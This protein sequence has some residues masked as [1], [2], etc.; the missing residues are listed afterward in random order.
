MKTGMKL[1]TKYYKRR[2]WKISY[3]ATPLSHNR[4]RIVK[5]YERRDAIGEAWSLV[6]HSAYE[7][8]A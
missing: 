8:S 3:T 4:L 6:R 2:L 5:F 7:A 1:S